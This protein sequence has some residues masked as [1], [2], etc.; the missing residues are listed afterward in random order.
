MIPVKD[1]ILQH[2]EERKAEDV[3]SD[4]IGLFI[5]SMMNLVTKSKMS[6]KA[7]A[8]VF[9]DVMQKGRDRFTAWLEKTAVPIWEKYG[10]PEI[11]TREWGR[12]E[13]EFVWTYLIDVTTPKMKQYVKKLKA[14]WKR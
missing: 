12:F 8:N 7:A 2:L 6:N 3:K 4:E 13:E 9:H 11:G 5:S 14:G 1:R 10:Y